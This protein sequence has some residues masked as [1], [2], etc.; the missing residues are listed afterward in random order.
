MQQ[1]TRR[2]TFTTYDVVAPARSCT[3]RPNDVVFED[4]LVS[5]VKPVR[6]ICVPYIIASDH[7]KSFGAGHL[8]VRAPA[9]TDL[10][11]ASVKD[12]GTSEQVAVSDVKV[13][14]TLLDMDF[15]ISL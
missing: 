12:R 11:T 15:N 14:A 4:D 9:R 10:P 3:S 13:L 6:R 2:D 8:A 1:L 7:T 5:V